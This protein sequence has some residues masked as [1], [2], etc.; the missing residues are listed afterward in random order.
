LKEGLPAFGPPRDG[1]GL[2]LRLFES[3][4]QRAGQGLEGE[5]IGA[6]ELDQLAELGGLLRPDL[7]GALQE[8]LEFGVIVS[9]FPRH[10]WFLGFRFSDSLLPKYCSLPSQALSV[11]AD[12]VC[13][14]G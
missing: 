1:F 14:Q 10:R 12:V 9:R 8:G 13:R 5:G 7:P 4:E 11:F 6:D 3:G 2:L